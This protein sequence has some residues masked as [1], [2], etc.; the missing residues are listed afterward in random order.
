MA[1]DIVLSKKLSKFEQFFFIKYILKN[2]CK[3][4]CNL[5]K[6]VIE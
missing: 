6:Y 3:D 1:C 4:L 2:L 5:N